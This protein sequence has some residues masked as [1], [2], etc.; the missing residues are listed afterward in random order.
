MYINTYQ[1]HEKC[2]SISRKSVHVKPKV[3]VGK[4]ETNPS[5]FAHTVAKATFDG[6][7]GINVRRR[8]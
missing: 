8:N 7:A 5:I 4:D 2:Q 1:M 6:M 3:Y